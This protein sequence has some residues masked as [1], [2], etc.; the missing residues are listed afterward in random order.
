MKTFIIEY[1]DLVS[2]AMPS[3]SYILGLCIQSKLSD[4]RIRKKLT[5]HSVVAYQA[6]QAVSEYRFD[7]ELIFASWV[8]KMYQI[9]CAL[10]CIKK[11]DQLIVNRGN[12]NLVIFER[13]G[14]DARTNSLWTKPNTWQS[15]W[16]LIKVVN[17][18]YEQ[19]YT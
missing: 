15:S 17:V 16:F 8:N 4:T 9:R 5:A 18:F 14:S 3:L 12:A 2:V 19:W 10:T 13:V 6:G 1:E 11:T 7:L